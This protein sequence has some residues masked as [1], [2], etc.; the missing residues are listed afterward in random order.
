[1]E[2]LSNPFRIANSLHHGTS[3][4]SVR[5]YIPPRYSHNFLLFLMTMSKGTAEIQFDAP[6]SFASL[7]AR[8]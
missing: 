1:M 4:Y 6:G 5:N 7:T 3:F 8:S 2:L